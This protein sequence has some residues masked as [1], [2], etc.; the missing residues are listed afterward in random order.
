MSAF[1]DQIK[2]WLQVNDMPT[3]EQF[4]SWVD[5]TRLKDEPILFTDMGQSFIELINNLGQPIQKIEATGLFSY[6]I[7]AGF[8]VEWILVKPTQD[9]TVTIDDGNG[10][11]SDVDVIAIH[12]EPIT[13][14]YNAGI[15]RDISIDGLPPKTLVYV[16]RYKLPV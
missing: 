8:I 11:A 16:K 7:P 3:E 2:Q 1:G 9:C 5:K 10:N 14:M 13:C 15:D 12:G 6:P 4:A